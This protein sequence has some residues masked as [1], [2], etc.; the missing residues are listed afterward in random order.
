[1][2]LV[3]SISTATAEDADAVAAVRNAAAMRLTEEFGTGH[4]SGFTSTPSVLRGIN[5]SRVLIAR[6]GN[7]PVATLRLATKRP[8]AIDADYFAP[9]KRPLYL[10]DMAVV[11][12]A[13]RAGVGRRLLGA[14]VEIARGWEKDAIRLDAYDHAAGAGPFYEKCG[15]KDVGRVTYR[16]VPLIY[17]Q[18]LL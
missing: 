8:W 18:L 12:T 14:A 9:S 7:N 2:T 4:W 10:V 3:L 15:F 13:Q 5:S 16:G 11:P 17:Y 6:E 1:M